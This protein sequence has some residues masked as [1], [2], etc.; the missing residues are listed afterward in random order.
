MNADQDIRDLFTI[1]HDGTIT[2]WE[3]DTNILTLKVDCIYL[4]ERIDRQFEQFFI[5]L[6]NISLLR[7]ETWETHTQIFTQVS[8]IFRAELEIMSAEVKEDHVAVFCDQ[9]DLNVSYCGGTLRIKCESYRIMDQSHSE[10]SL[11]ELKAISTAY[12]TNWSKHC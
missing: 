11:D 2:A 12:W 7:L 1:L 10:L 3:G 4:A 5:R 8:D 6:E 9:F